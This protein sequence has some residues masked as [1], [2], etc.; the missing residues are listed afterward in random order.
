MRRRR[1]RWT[2]DQVTARLRRRIVVQEEAAK[3]E[4][5]RAEQELAQGQPD[6]GRVERREIAARRAA[7]V[8]V[9]LR[10]AVSLLEARA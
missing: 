3:Q 7:D 5:L 8:A 4:W 6:P 2:R 1:A 10:E 9:G